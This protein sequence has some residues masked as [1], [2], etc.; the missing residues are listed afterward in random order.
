M[1]LD[2]HIHSNYSTDGQ[3]SPREILKNARTRGM[4]GLAITDHNKLKGS[5]Q[6]F[7]M[8]G[9]FGLVVVRGVEISSEDGHVLA[10]GIDN[11]IKRGMSAKRTVHEIKKIGGFAVISHPYRVWSGVGERATRTSKAQALETF[12]ARS[13][14]R[15]NQKAM[16]LCKKMKLPMTAGSDAHCL[17]DVGRAYVNIK[18]QL[19]T[20]EQVL[21]A[22][23]K[24]RA[25]V[26]GRSRT[27]SESF[28]YAYK[29]VTQWIGRGFK[30]M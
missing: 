1:I 19:E 18:E 14:M 28:G 13:K 17:D 9:E 26:G 20:E 2:L 3:A 22:L 8:A 16:K 10:Y 5:I 15:H 6:A 30:K 25:S 21:E 29:S 7:P 23:R 4:D 27:G 24:G 12:N 11:E